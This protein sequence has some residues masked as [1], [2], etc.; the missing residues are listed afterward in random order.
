M[1]NIPSSTLFD[2]L[3]AVSDGEILTT[4][5]AKRFGISPSLLAYYCK[6]GV[7][8]R[9][10]RGVYQP[11][12]SKFHTPKEWQ[13]VVYTTLSIPSGVI[14]LI[15]ALAYYELTDQAARE[16]W[17]AVPRK[18]RSPKRLNSRIVHLSNMTLGVHEVEFG[19]IR[20]KIF[21]RERTI[22]DAFRLLSKEIAIK[23]L[24]LYMKRNTE[25]KPNLKKLYKYAKL[26]R[27]DISSYIEAIA[28]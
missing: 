10:N 23:A 20:V 7:L 28:T 12:D 16:I 21:D 13:D 3:L 24:K 17:I 18:T 22:I 19:D 1:K 26:L 6:R 27:T 2:K 8:K 4:S 15:T 25:H 11:R 5:A 9:I 14:C